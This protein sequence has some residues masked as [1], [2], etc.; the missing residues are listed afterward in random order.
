MADPDNPSNEELEILKLLFIFDAMMKMQIMCYYSTMPFLANKFRVDL[1]F[2]SL[3]P[4]VLFSMVPF[5]YRHKRQILVNFVHQIRSNLKDPNKCRKRKRQQELLLSPL[6]PSR[7]RKKTKFDH[8]RGLDCVN[9]DYWGPQAKWKGYKFERAFGVNRKLAQR[10]VR[11]CQEAKPRCFLPDANFKNP[12]L[13]IAAH[14]KVLNVLK[15]LRFGTPFNA[16]EDYFQVSDETVRLAQKRFFEAI[17]ND[18]SL[19]RDF[20]RPMYRWDAVRVTKL[21]KA[22]NGVDG[23]VL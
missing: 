12:V 10:L 8:A 2:M 4:S 22:K 15:T 9:Q 21:H 13:Q 14:V 1:E 20:L 16:F 5:L 11:V 18:K 7:K 3:V 17:T 6:S 19:L 23:R